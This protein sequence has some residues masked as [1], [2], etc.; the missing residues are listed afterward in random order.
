[1]D[2]FMPS[3]PDADSPLAAVLRQ[4]LWANLRMLD[5]CAA[6]NDEQLTA[7]VAG[8][9]GRIDKTLHHIFRAEQGYLIDMT[10]SD[11]GD[12]LRRELRPED[13]F[14]VEVLRAH[15]LETG[16]A[17]IKIAANL[18][19]G[20]ISNLD[21]PEEGTRWPVPTALILAQALNHATEHRAH[22]MT[23]MTQLGIEP[24]DVTGW[25]Y[26]EEIV[27]GIPLE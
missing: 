23:T 8:T 21:N 26:I 3:Q 10:G 18:Q 6:L 11:P 27:V 24:P 25:G 1:M 9:Y 15:A 17:F 12:L 4:H 13:E 5:A 14:D 20:A 22:I 7:T 19:P 16:E 2:Q